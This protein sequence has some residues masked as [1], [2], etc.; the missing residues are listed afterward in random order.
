MVNRKDQIHGT[1]VPGIVARGDK[2]DPDPDK[3]GR[4]AIREFVHGA[5]VKT[6][7]LPFIQQ[8]T[9]NQHE[10]PSALRPG[11]MVW[12]MKTTDGY[13]FITGISMGV[14]AHKDGNIENLI[15]PFAIPP[16]TTTGVNIPP[17][18]KHKT[19]SNRSGLSKLYKEIQEKS[20]EDKQELYDGLPSHGAI[21]SMA[22]LVSNPVMQVSTGLTPLE[23]NL[24]TDTLSQ[25]AGTMFSIGNLL[26]FLDSV[27]QKAN[28]T[29]TLSSDMNKSMNNLFLLKQGETGTGLPGNFMMGGTVDPVSFVTQALELI[30]GVTSVGQLDDALTKISDLS[31]S[32][33]FGLG[34]IV[35]SIQNLFG[36][37]QKTISAN[38]NISISTNDVIQ[39][40]ENLFKSLASSIPSSDASTPLFGNN[41]QVSTLM[42]RLNTDTQISKAKENIEKKSPSSSQARNYLTNG[43]FKSIGSKNY[44][45]GHYG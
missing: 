18:V 16:K 31:F 4:V 27:G 5:G 38:G 11:Q 14:G 36:D 28:L 41:S 20:Q 43:F 29:S 19:S 32:F 35:L 1:I 44:F 40:I 10:T 21:A 9:P 33:S 2:S 7:H 45:E 34:D 30:K 17:N 8:M 39:E 6:K 37:A 3:S 24:G 42:K 23:I 13:S 15:S 25:M 12:T 22:G 26:T